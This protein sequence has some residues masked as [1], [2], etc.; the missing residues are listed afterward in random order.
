MPLKVT[1]NK[2]LQLHHIRHEV[3]GRDG[4]VEIRRGRNPRTIKAAKPMATPIMI[5]ANSFRLRRAVV[6]CQ[7]PARR[8]RRVPSSVAQA[9]CRGVKSVYDA[10]P[11]CATCGRA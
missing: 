4:L 2:A 10:E 6:Q 5:P 8:P 3:E 11:I 9:T 7:D 1:A